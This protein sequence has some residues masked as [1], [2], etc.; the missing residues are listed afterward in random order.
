MAFHPGQGYS[1]YCELLGSDQHSVFSFILALARKETELTVVTAH[2]CWLVCIWDCL[3]VEHAAQGDQ[4]LSQYPQ[5]CYLC[6]GAANSV[7]VSQ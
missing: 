5:W 1:D 2:K 3:L 4:N 7:R 6:S